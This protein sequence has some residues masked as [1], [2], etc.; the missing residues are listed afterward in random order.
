MGSISWTKQ[1]KGRDKR[2]IVLAKLVKFVFDV[3]IRY[4]LFT[5]FHVNFSPTLLG[6]WYT[7]TDIGKL[8]KD[9]LRDMKRRDLIRVTSAE[10]DLELKKMQEN[11][12]PLLCA[13]PARLKFVPKSSKYR[14]IVV[15]D[16]DV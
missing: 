6:M 11:E 3:Y 9:L 7:R 14:H 4:L 16:K 8:H 1:V 2:Y 10:E 15:A 12:E 5:R 13:P